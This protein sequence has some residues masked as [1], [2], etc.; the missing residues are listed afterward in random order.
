MKPRGTFVIVAALWLAV[1][2][3]ALG[4]AGPAVAY[5]KVEGMT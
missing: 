2:A 5:L 1:H 4:A 3:M